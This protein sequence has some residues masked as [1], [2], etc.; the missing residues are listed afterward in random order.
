MSACF[1]GKNLLP[2][3]MTSLDTKTKVYLTTLLRTRASKL[4]S[5]SSVSVRQHAPH[6]TTQSR[7]LALSA[8]LNSA[9]GSKQSGLR[10]PSLDQARYQSM[11]SSKQSLGTTNR[12]SLVRLPI[13]SAEHTF[14]FSQPDHENSNVRNASRCMAICLSETC[15]C[16]LITP[17]ASP[18][19]T[20]T[21]STGGK[22]HSSLPSY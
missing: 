17:L 21:A 7:C 3:A 8:W 5:C 12:P 4:P 10:W 15:V 14:A 22:F 16:D 2:A 20:R 13:A 9:P 19:L 11:S 6:H 18:L 1:Q